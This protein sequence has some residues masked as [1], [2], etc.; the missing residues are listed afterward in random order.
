MKEIKV[1]VKIDAESFKEELKIALKEVIQ[2]IEIEKEK[3]DIDKFSMVLSECIKK[4]VILG[5]CY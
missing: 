1:N 5:K 2:E 4:N 3:I